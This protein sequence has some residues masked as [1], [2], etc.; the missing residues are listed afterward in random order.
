MKDGKITL[1]RDRTE[2]GYKQDKNSNKTI[3]CDDNGQERHACYK[4]FYFPLSIEKRRIVK[5]LGD[6]K[7][8]V[9]E[10]YIR[11][12]LDREQEVLSVL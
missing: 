10:V 3:G 5:D 1:Q 6:R 9:D 12:L 4:I 2:K 11:E 8:C 7:R